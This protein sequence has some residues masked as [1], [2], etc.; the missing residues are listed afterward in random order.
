MKLVYMLAPDSC[1]D[2]SGFGHQPGDEAVLC[3]CL[4]GRMRRELA[5]GRDLEA[6]HL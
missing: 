2:C 6:L 4:A 5:V 3:A 1:P